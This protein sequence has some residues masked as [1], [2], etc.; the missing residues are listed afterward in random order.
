MSRAKFFVIALSCSFLWYIVPGYLFTTLTTIS[1]VCWVFSK[2]V[3][4]QQLGSGTH[5]LGLGALTLDWSA[6]AS[7]LSSP[8]ISPFFAILNVF[9]GKTI[10]NLKPDAALFRLSCFPISSLKSELPSALT[11]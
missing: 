6:V 7:F 11:P 4:A 5:G 9:V 10:N 8:L 2:S 1:W 3:T